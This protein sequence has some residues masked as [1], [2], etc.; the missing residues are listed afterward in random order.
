MIQFKVDD[1]AVETARL[2]ARSVAEALRAKLDGEALAWSCP[3]T[4]LRT[5]GHPLFDAV[6]I[7]FDKHRPL[8]LSPDAI[9]LTIAHGFA[10]YVNENAEAL[11]PRFVRHEGK[12]TLKVEVVAEG[13]QDVPWTEAVEEFASKIADEVGPGLVRLVE[14]DFT[15]TTTAEKVASRVVLMDAFQKY[16]EYVIMCVCGIPFVRLL[17]TVSDW[18]SVRERVDVLREYDAGDGHL[19]A[20]VATLSPLLDQFVAAAEGKDRRAFFQHIYKPAQ[21][22]GPIRATGWITQFFPYMRDHNDALQP[23]RLAPEVSANGDWVYEGLT[24]DSLPVSLGCAPVTVLAGEVSHRCELRGGLLGV[25]TRDDHA[26]APIAGWVASERTLLTRLDNLHLD[27][28]FGFVRNTEGLP[29]GAAALPSDLQQLYAR[30]REVTVTGVGRFP[31]LSP[32]VDLSQDLVVFVYDDG[33]T[34]HVTHRGFV[35]S[36]PGDAESERWN[37]EPIARGLLELLKRVSPPS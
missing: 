19:R 1:V 22:Y 31:P 13:P 20:Y 12:K 34:V 30:F 37:R 29:K 7:A 5:P 2:P 14:C 17:G 9:W 26:V 18:K 36:L 11:R 28:A 3:D 21:A 23:R 33:R 24:S 4:L 10:M 25:V 32:E 35:E 27:S 8:E 15:T 6:Q 16:F